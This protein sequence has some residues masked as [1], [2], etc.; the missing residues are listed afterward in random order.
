MPVAKRRGR[1]RRKYGNANDAALTKQCRALY[2]WSQGEL[3]EQ[4]GVTQGSVSHIEQELRPL[5]TLMRR[6]VEALIAM[7]RAGA[8]SASFQAEEITRASVRL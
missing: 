6:E 1:R 3:G 8:K 5:T 4:L 7:Q 2:G